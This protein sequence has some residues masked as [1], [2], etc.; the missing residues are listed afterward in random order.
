MIG[1]PALRTSLLLGTSLIVLAVACALSASAALARVGVTTASDGDPLGKPPNENERILR[2]GI[3]VQ[4]NELVTTNANDRAHLVFLDGSSLTVGPNARLAIDRF[5]FDPATMEGDLVVNATKGVFRLVGGRISKRKPITIV[6][7]SSTIGIRGG[8]TVVSVTETQTVANFVFGSSMTVTSGGRTET[9]TRTGSQ[10]VTAA[11]GVPGAPTLLKPG[12]LSAP[13]SQLEGTT[14]G[15][16]RKADQSAQ[17]SG[18]ASRNSGQA[19]NTAPNGPPNTSSNTLVNAVNNAT[20]ENQFATASQNKASART[21]VIATIPASPASSPINPSGPTGGSPTASQTAGTSRTSQTLTGIAGGLVF[22]RPD[23]ATALLSAP[24]GVS[25]TT[26]ATTG[27][28]KGTVVLQDIAGPG[29]STV[30]TLQLG[31]VGGLG[32]GNSVFVDDKTFLAVTQYNDLS[33]LSSWREGGQERQ[34]TDTSVLASA[35]AVPDPLDLPLQLPLQPQ[36]PGTPG[37]CT[38]EFL[39]WGWWAAK[40]PDPFDGT[41]TYTAVGPYVAGKLANAVQLPQTGTATYN[42][43]MS[44]VASSHGS[45]YAA[46]GTYQ[47]VWNFGAR[48][49]VFSGTFDGRGYAGA[50]QAT[51]GSNG[52]AFAGSF[53]GGSRSGSLNGA[54]F[55]SP[56]DPAAYQAGTFSIGG[57]QYKASGVFA[58]QR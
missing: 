25:I 2:I 31:G 6:T 4:A 45:A 13:F 34:V 16:D 49:G 51:P 27:Q 36:A 5:V 38:C 52:A 29:R 50:T 26:D 55:S 33:R 8:I 47:N 41:R 54:F 21:I 11:G 30:T 57:S 14:A 56:A 17:Q 24:A 15:A 1:V 53:S 9:A 19:A 7:P 3:D 28:A 35:R 20:V 32:L 46:T 58:G 37:A 18:F 23:S 48:S 22:G 12:S 40:M 43:F 39:T 42:G 44:G 10:I